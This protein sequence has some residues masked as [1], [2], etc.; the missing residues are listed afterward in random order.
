[1]KFARY[2]FLVAGIYGLLV[3]FPLYIAEAKMS[4][5]YPP[6]MNHLEYYY[7]FIGVTIAW[8]VLFLFISRNPLRMRPVMIVC[9]LEKLSLVPTYMVLAPRGLFPQMWIPLMLIDLLLGVLFVI[10]YMKTK[11]AGPSSKTL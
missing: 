1:M 7:S 2:V 8:Q 11:E 4:A 10:S 9:P 3:T 5:D 6:V